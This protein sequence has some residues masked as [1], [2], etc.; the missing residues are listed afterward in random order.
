MSKSDL[1]LTSKLGPRTAAFLRRAV[2]QGTSVQIET[3]GEPVCNVGR[4]ARKLAI[5]AFAA[6]AAGPIQ[7]QGATVGDSLITVPAITIDGQPAWHGHASDALQGLSHRTDLVGEGEAMTIKAIAACTPALADVTPAIIAHGYEAMLQVDPT[8][9]FKAL[10]AAFGEMRTWAANSGRNVEVALA[11]YCRMPSD[12]RGQIRTWDDAVR[13]LADRPDQ[14]RAFIRDVVLNHRVAVYR[15]VAQA[16]WEYEAHASTATYIQRHG[17][18][19]HVGANYSDWVSAIAAVGRGVAELAG[20][21][22]ASDVAR[23]ISG[24]GHSSSSAVRALG[25]IG[26]GRTVADQAVR[27]GRSLADLA[28]VGREVRE[29]YGRMD[30]KEVLSHRSPRNREVTTL[31]FYS[32]AA[33]RG[34]YRVSLAPLAGQALP[35]GHPSVVATQDTNIL[36]A[37]AAA[38]RNLMEVV[39][40]DEYGKAHGV[41]MDFGAMYREYGRLAD[42]VRERD[43]AENNGSG[44]Y[45]RP[46]D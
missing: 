34:G 43:V 42:G 17:L 7:E 22:R 9:S 41:H 5:I 44:S 10:L 40:L 39:R 3:Y 38:E 6:T 2:E 27:A 8:P 31:R 46:R 20:D 29:A 21:R 36:R 35:S 25:A 23:G 26:D 24:V 16:Q 12:W 15:E 33:K 14:A 30:N 13:D 28:R 32:D 18:I 45:P 11:A 19:R 1:N 4:L 37:K